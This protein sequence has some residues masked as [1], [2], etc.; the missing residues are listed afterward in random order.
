MIVSGLVSMW[1]LFP[2]NVSLHVTIL[3]LNTVFGGVTLGW[4][5]AEHWEEH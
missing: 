1:S 5:G 2:L 4:R 3:P